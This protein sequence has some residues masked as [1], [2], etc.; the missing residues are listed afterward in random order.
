MSKNKSNEN[1]SNT[2]DTRK[3][4][5]NYRKSRSRRSTENNTRTDRTVDANKCDSRSN[6][7][8]NDP[9]W[10]T[11][12][13]ALVQNAGSFSFNNA[14][15]NVLYGTSPNGNDRAIPGVFE[16]VVQMV[17][18]ISKD[19]F[20]PINIAAR[21]LYDKVNYKNS[22]NFSYDA[23]DLMMYMYGVS[24]AYAYWAW[25]VRV[26]GIMNTYSQINRYVPDVLVK[27]TGADPDSIRLNMAQFRYYIN[28]YA[29]KINVLAAPQ[30]MP[31]FSRYMWLFS[32]V[33][34]DAPNKKAG[35]YISKPFGFYKYV[36]NT[37]TGGACLM[38]PF[39]DSLKSLDDIV[40]YGNAI[41]EALLGSQDINNMS[42][43]ILKAFEG[44][45]LSLPD[46]ADDYFVT[47]AYSMEVLEQLHNTRCF[48]DY[49]IGGTST[50]STGLVTVSPS[51][52]LIQD[53]TNGYLYFEMELANHD[54]YA[55]FND[56]QIML[57]SFSDNPTPEQVFVMTRNICSIDHSTG[58]L[59]ECG[60][61][62]IIKFRVWSREKGKL[63]FAPSVYWSSYIQVNGPGST[64]DAYVTLSR[65]SYVDKF[66]TYPFIWALLIAASGGVQSASMFGD[67]YN[68]T[69]ID[70][71]AL[72]K[73]HEAALLSVFTLPNTLGSE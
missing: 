35:L 67:V 72:H 18:G 17:P 46:T 11:N 47:P 60:T 61:D 8:N 26:Y 66:D 34:M 3:D 41:A 55:R 4:S 50:D 71:A 21:A 65:L 13:K 23:P 43:D 28:L 45:C 52:H 33:F 69:T 40:T 58:D 54:L 49:V 27:A 24:S 53:P 22:R 31:V 15:G 16:Y 32:N 51:G 14:M 36:E 57:D 42:T 56:T 12:N 64:T 62:V 19:P 30:G 37:T 2:K 7:S 68:F 59:S 9:G 70:D 63:E 1:G 6:G 5:R 44:N 20:S 73:L 29:R 25:M 10:Y 48:G 38:Q 39:N